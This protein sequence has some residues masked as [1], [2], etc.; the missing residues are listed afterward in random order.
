MCIPDPEPDA[1][2]D[3]APEEAPDMVPEEA[4]DMVPEE[5]PTPGDTY[6]PRHEASAAQRDDA[7]Q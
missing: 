5:A 7:A 3:V 6:P 1:A 2:P 4:P